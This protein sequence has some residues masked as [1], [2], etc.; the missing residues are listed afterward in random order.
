MEFLSNLNSHLAAYRVSILSEVDAPAVQKL[1][2]ACA[3]FNLLVSGLPPAPGD[4]LDLF[5]DLPPGKSLADK[6]VIGVYDRPAHLAGL[7]DVIRGYPEEDTW[8]IGLLLLE[9]SARGQGLG[10]RFYQEIERWV[11]QNGARR[12]KLGVVGDNQ[13]GCRFWQA[14]GFQEIGVRPPRKFGE[15]EQVVYIMERVLETKI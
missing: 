4:G 3:D 6:A 14:L 15:K 9:P 13:D 11:R 8:F 2:E 1:L 10:R 7:A 5:R 12:I